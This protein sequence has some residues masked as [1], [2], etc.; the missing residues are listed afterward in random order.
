MSDKYFTL[1][2]VPERSDKVRKLTLPTL[3][4]RIVSIVGAIVVF[5]GIYIFF[6]YL[7]VISQ[8]AENKRLRSE[9]HILRM[10][11]QAAK[12]R[13]DSLEQSVTR[14][15]SFAQKLRVLGNLDSVQGSKLLSEPEPG[16][17]GTGNVQ[18]S[19]DSGTI[20]DPDK[21]GSVI[22]PKDEEFA[23]IVS[24]PNVHAQM[25]RT[26]SAS[27]LGGEL[28]ANFEAQ[29][30]LD[31]I[32]QIAQGAAKLREITESEE[33]GYAFL[34]DLLQ[35][36]VERLLATPSVTP[37]RGYISSEFGFRYNPFSGNRTFHAGIDIANHVGTKIYAPADGLVTFVG[38][39]GGFGNVVRLD[40]GFG[41]VSKFGHNSKILIKN[42]TRVKRGD[43][44]AE[45]GSSG[46]STGPHLHYQIEIKGR[47]VNPRHFILEDTF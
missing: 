28:S 15:K 46:R 14:L 7:H 35:E 1:M 25:E 11:V 9:N 20:E 38:S 33:Q 26:R 44:L 10:D 17:G 22:L 42:G 30:L 5:A 6:D 41:I 19:E 12:N 4:L 32:N 24:N 40:H 37:A 18:D 45:M 16:T 21:H 34:S 2:L 8:V 39:L 47:P 13:L 3:Y 31:Q 27:L 36:K 23:R 29:G 43:L